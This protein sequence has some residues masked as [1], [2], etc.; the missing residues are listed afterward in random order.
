MTETPLSVNDLAELHGPWVDNHFHMNA[1]SDLAGI[2][3]SAD[4]AGVL[5]MVC[6]GTDVDSS[7][8]CIERA[9]QSDRIWATAG[10]HPHD[11]AGG[12]AGLR[13]IFVEATEQDL[14]LVAVGE[15]GLDFHYDH[16]PRAEQRQVFSEQISIAHEFNLP[17][18]IHTRS[19]WTETFEILD[20]EGIPPRTVFHCFTGGPAEAT[21]AIERGAM[22]SIS[23]IV[24]FPSADDVRS[25]VEIAPLSSLMVETDSPFL[26]P[27]PHRGRPN[28]PALVGLIGSRVAGVKG[29]DVGEVALATTRNASAFYG[30]GLEVL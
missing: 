14:R 19:A 20:S 10:V 29:I 28:E 23:G 9:A 22:L 26:T 27:V 16:S 25:A 2:L 12:I 1:E 8:H 21:G 18:V 15:C 4:D 24:T 5:A 3:A 30:L 17:L 11:A 7:R 13:E 6:V